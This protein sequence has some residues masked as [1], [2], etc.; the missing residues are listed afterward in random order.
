MSF[1]I[2]ASLL[3]YFRFDWTVLTVTFYIDDEERRLFSALSYA[4]VVSL[5]R[6]T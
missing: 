1:L 6:G 4:E 5:W 2:Q 3:A